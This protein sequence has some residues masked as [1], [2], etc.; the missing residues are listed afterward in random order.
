[1]ASLIRYLTAQ[2]DYLCALETAS[3][4]REGAAADSQDGAK[5]PPAAVQGRPGSRL[6]PGNAGLAG[7]LRLGA[8]PHSFSGRAC[9]LLWNHVS[10]PAGLL[11][12]VGNLI[13]DDKG[14]PRARGAEMPRGARVLA[15]ILLS[16]LAVP[17]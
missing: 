11:T 13:E 8:H 16:S 9:R 7:G 15:G 17:V 4:A 6:R 12:G 3:S 10:S 5:A 1:M 2:A 14:Y